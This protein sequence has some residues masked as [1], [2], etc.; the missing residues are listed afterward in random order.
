MITDKQLE[1]LGFDIKVTKDPASDTK[2]VTFKK[3]F[4]KVS[5]TDLFNQETG[6]HEKGEQTVFVTLP[7]GGP[8][9]NEAP[10]YNIKKIANLEQLDKLLNDN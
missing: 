10:L 1:Q 7:V 4:L 6:R 3:G 5:R 2:F 8:W 9:D